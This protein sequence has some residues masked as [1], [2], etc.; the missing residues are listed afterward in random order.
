MKSFETIA[1]EATS[2]DFHVVAE[3]AGCSGKN[4]QMVVK[5]LRRDNFN[6]QLIF[7]EYLTLKEELK[8]HRK[9]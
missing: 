7:S 5:R 6:I 4:V 8:R 9:R 1:E 2:R 3:I